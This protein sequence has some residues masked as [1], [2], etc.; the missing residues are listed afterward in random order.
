MIRA[1]TYKLIRSPML[2]IG[3]WG[4]FFLCFTGFFTGEFVFGNRTVLYYMHDFIDFGIYR[5]ALI[6]FGALPFTVNFAD[7]WTSGVAKECIIRSGV[8][9]YA[10]ANLLFCW[11]SSLLTVFLGM[12]FFMGFYSLFVP[13]SESYSYSY[14]LL[15]GQFLQNG[16]GEIFLL[17]KTLIFS[18]SCAMWATMGMLMSV[19]FPNKFIAI[20]SPFVLSYVIER[21]TTLLP[22]DWNLDL[23]GISQ[24]FV[25]T[26]T[27][28][29]LGGF[30]YC[31]GVLTIISAVCGVIFYICSKRKVQNEL[32]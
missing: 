8:K 21:A 29:D 11:L 12:T 14:F 26:E 15:F 10:A 25:L 2:Y 17:L 20:C 19:F 23:Q 30:L 13:L 7:E 22:A 28:G 6:V 24:S 9:K 3:I 16:H 31:V 5:K 4:A 1:Y 32:V 18:F 27:F